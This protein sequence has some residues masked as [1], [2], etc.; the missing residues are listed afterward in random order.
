MYQAVYGCLVA[1]GEATYSA[2]ISYRVET[3]APLARLLF[4]ELNHSITPGRHRVTVYYD[5]YMAKDVGV[6]PGK[7]NAVDFADGLVHAIC[8]LP[9]IS[10]CTTVS[11]A[12]LQAD[13]LASNINHGW[14]KEPLGRRLQGKECDAEDEMLSEHLVAAALLQEEQTGKQRRNS[15]QVAFPI[16]LGPES[17]YVSVHLQSLG[18][19]PALNYVKFLHSIFDCWECFSDRPS[20]PTNRA[21]ARFLRDKMGM[22][23]E[24]VKRSQRKSVKESIDW[25]LQLERWVGYETFY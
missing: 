9:L 3:D 10:N 21:V 6:N 4:D 17:R 20:Q 13:S 8:F 22:S 16:F 2:F 25:L 18:F 14:E 24:E 23:V 11:L 19:S 5:T 7:S 15:L 12:A 1:R